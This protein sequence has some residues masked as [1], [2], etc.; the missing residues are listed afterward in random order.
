LLRR[1]SGRV[2]SH[3]AELFTG[4][5]VARRRDRAQDHPG[6]DGVG[7]RRY[8]S[9][10]LGCCA[11]VR[12]DLVVRRNGVEHRKGGHRPHLERKDS[13]RATD[14]TSRCA[15]RRGERWQGEV[16]ARWGRPK[17][18]LGGRLDRHNRVVARHCGA[19]PLTR[20]N[21][22][23]RLRK[24]RGGCGPRGSPP[25]PRPFRPQR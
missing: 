14:G 13:R 23:C 8:R 12:S 7:R 20:F 5:T 22:S 21:R 15:V 9:R 4:R 6:R 24:G 18:S 3:P 11:R 16:L 2:A 1:L 10:D 25:A 17:S 19:G